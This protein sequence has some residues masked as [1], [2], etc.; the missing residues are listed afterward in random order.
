MRELVGQD[1]ESFLAGAQRAV[2]LRCRA[3][4]V[5]ERQ[6]ALE[7][8]RV[9]AAVGHDEVVRA[10]LQPGRREPVVEARDELHL[11]RDLALGAARDPD[12]LV[13]GMRGVRVLS[14]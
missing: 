2:P 10:R 13:V 12:Q 7:H 14:R 5:A 8:E 11:D 3:L 4:G 9:G 6:L 1:D